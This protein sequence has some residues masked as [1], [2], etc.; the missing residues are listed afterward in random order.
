MCGYGPVW[1]LILFDQ[2]PYRGVWVSTVCVWNFNIS[3]KIPIG[4]CSVWALGVGCRDFNF[5]DKNPTRVWTLC[6]VEL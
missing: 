5:L 4:M 2:D 1:F 6:G 3:K